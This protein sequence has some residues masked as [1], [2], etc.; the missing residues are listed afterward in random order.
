MYPHK[1]LYMNAQSS[2]IDDSSKV[3]TTQMSINWQID[4]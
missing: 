4:K 1:N 3:E 2:I